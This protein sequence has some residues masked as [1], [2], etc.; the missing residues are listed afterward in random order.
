MRLPRRHRFCS[1]YLFG[2]LLIFGITS[3]APTWTSAYELSAI[4]KQDIPTVP[5]LDS[6]PA[7]FIPNLGQTDPTVRF[8]AHS[9]GGLAFFAPDEVV[10]KLPPPE[11]ISAQHDRATLPYQRIRR[12]R[13]KAALT[14]PPAVLRIRFDGANPTPDII[15]TDRSPEIVN[16]FV[17]DDPAKWHTNLPTYAGITY[18]QLYPGIDLHYEGTGAHTK[19]TYIV[20]PG[21]DASRIRWRYVGA[22]SLSVG[23]DASLSIS[24]D[25]LKG[26][27][28]ADQILTEQAPVA[29]QD[30]G[31]QRV[32]VAT[33]Y[34]LNDDG[35]IGFVLGQYNLTYQLTVD[36]ILTYNSYLGGSGLDQAYGVAADNSQNI[37][38]TGYTISTN[39]P[40]VNGYDSS[41][42]G[43]IDAFV[44]KIQNGT[45]VYSTYLGGSNE[46]FGRG[47]AVDNGGRVYI[48]GF[49]VSTNF[50]TVNAYDST[51]NGGYDAFVAMLNPGLSGSN[52]LI[53]ST[54]LG[55]SGEE[56]GVGIAVAPE[57]NGTYR[58]YVSGDTTSSAFPTVN[59]NDASFN[60]GYND[61]FVAKLNP[62]V[63]GSSSLLYSTFLGGSG[64]D[65]GLA[66]GVDSTRKAYVT[67]GTQGNG[68]ST[69]N[70]YNPSYA[71][72]SSDG[73]VAKFDP[74]SSGSSSLLYSTFLGGN[75][76]DQPYAIAVD[77]GGIAYITGYTQSTNF[78]TPNAEDASH[79]GDLDAF[80]TTLNPAIPG[81]GSL[82]AGT[83]L[84][85]S[86]TEYGNGIAVESNS[87][88]SGLRI[89]TVAGET[90]STNFPFKGVSAAQSSN[91]GLTDAFVAKYSMP[92][93]ANTFAG[94]RLFSGYLG[95]S[96]SDGASAVAV[97]SNG[98]IYMTGYGANAGS[99]D[100]FVTKIFPEYDP[101]CHW[102]HTSGTTTTIFY[103][104]GA[105]L[106][107]P[108]TGWRNAFTAAISSWSG[109]GRIVLTQNATEKILMTAPNDVAEPRG[110]F[111]VPTCSGA[112]LTYARVVVNTAVHPTPSQGLAAHEIGHAQGLGHIASAVVALIGNNPGTVS[113]PQPLDIELLNLIYP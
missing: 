86:S 4:Q 70:A 113:T 104:W 82:L 41:A 32:P 24:L 17:G 87:A 10:L 6:H 31:G 20:A 22:R 58:I 76:Y 49:T 53:Y 37:Y 99:T 36:P 75:D 60:G 30:I 19:S 47:I 85:G 112:L 71:G 3:I 8:Q 56:N 25:R 63:S 67:G 52:S 59:A 92:A 18:Q 97:D 68:F 5:D 77:T 21:A 74:S 57:T 80:V 1:T 7:A 91:H 26:Q 81:A 96:G 108:G 33:R 23:D 83:F 29:W 109:V 54:F 78:P 103:D 38:V 2:L 46:D 66:I 100:A 44:T 84:G 43:I 42:N 14:I 111:T 73:Y 40:T 12:D 64:I 39:F 101:Q 107:T 13:I 79:N 98:R 93:A 16:Y 89:V 102:P 27:S 15:A 105:G 88:G 69:K 35:S 50:P 9:M 90:A 110:A 94:R 45:R 48:I 11:L 55:S 51:A 95:G 34:V 106:T 65:D 28:P 72:G 61:A 62:F